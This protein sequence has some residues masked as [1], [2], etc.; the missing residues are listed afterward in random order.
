MLYIE[1]MNTKLKELMKNLN[2]VFG[3]ML[4]LFLNTSL[5]AQDVKRTSPKEWEE[6]VYGGRFIDLFLPIPEIGKL[7]SDTWGAKGVKP[8]YIDN[9]IED[10]EWSYWGGNI[11]Q[12]EDGI[13]HKFLCRW[14]EDSKKGHMEWPNSEVVHALSKNSLGPFKYQETIGKG[15]NPEIYKIKDGRFVLIVNNGYYV[16]SS[17]NG[18]WKYFKFQFDQRDRPVFDHI[19]NLTFSQRE[20]GSYLMVSRGGG[21]WFSQNGLPPFYQVSE[22]S[23]YPPYDGRY[24]DPVVWRTD[25]QYHLI[26]NDWL[27]RIAYHLRSKDGLNWKLDDLFHSK[28]IQS[29]NQK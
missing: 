3:L 17:L 11:I 13:Y 1:L 9:G 16:S 24:E 22:K 23:V 28:Y 14:R 12:D 4:F 8:R 6:L 7:T 2:L 18:P 26:V 19:A 10:K 5:N 27:G 29:L 25:F 20:D 15:H 21:I